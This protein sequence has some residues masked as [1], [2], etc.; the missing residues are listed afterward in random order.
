MTCPDEVIGKGTVPG[1]GLTS[2]RA[3]HDCPYG[4][5]RSAWRIEDGVF[6]LSA[7]I[8]PGPGSTC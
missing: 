1:G 7:A 6:T 2:A 8:P 4:R 5:I 3:E